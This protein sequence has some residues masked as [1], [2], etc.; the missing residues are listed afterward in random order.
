MVPLFSSRVLVL[1]LSFICAG[2]S[3][4]SP[5]KLLC[6]VFFLLSL[7]RV[8]TCPFLTSGPF[9]IQDLVPACDSEQLSVLYPCYNTPFSPFIFF[10]RTPLSGA[11]TSFA[12]P[13]STPL[14]PVKKMAPK[15][16]SVPFAQGMT[17][18]L[19]PNLALDALAPDTSQ[20][21]PLKFCLVRFLSPPSLMSVLP[22]SLVSS[23]WNFFSLL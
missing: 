12:Q 8:T 13:A 3:S 21:A 16:S 11:L 22:S 2:L 20:H 4:S 19:V 17:V 6:F 5:R 7:Q 9:I 18:S 1:A 14:I 23:C 15:A 10:W